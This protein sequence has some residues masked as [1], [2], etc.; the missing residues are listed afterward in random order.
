MR[1][2][3]E[4]SLDELADKRMRSI[5]KTIGRKFDVITM[6]ETDPHVT[7]LGPFDTNDELRL[8]R[9]ISNIGDKFNNVGF[10]I[11]HAGNFTNQVVFAKVS[12]SIELL[13]LQR[14]LQYKLND[15]C[16]FDYLPKYIP[17][18]TV[19]MS[20]ISQNFQS[21]MK[22]LKTIRLPAH[23]QFIR[24]IVI[25]KDFDILYSYDF[26]LRKLLDPVESLDKDVM[27]ESNRIAAIK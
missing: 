23:Q 21:I 4:F 10:R 14:V 7:L 5:I 2:L 26:A 13:N 15:Y 20:D 18:V 9:N 27:K 17:H 16:W 12:P 1:Y 8:F 19:A 11:T 22:Y 6:R 25:R 24:R 3:V